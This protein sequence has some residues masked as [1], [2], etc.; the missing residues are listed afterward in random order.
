MQQSTGMQHTES[1]FPRVLNP[2]TTPKFSF[3]TSNTQWRF[4]K[5]WH[6]LITNLETT[7]AMSLF[8][9]KY[10]SIQNLRDMILS[11]Y[12]SLGTMVEHVPATRNLSPNQLFPHGY[13]FKAISGCMQL[14]YSMK[15]TVSGFGFIICLYHGILRMFTHFWVTVPFHLKENYFRPIFSLEIFYFYTNIVVHKNHRITKQKDIDI[16]QSH[17]PET[18]P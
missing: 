6:Y 12:C 13:F 10:I 18:A 16:T 14:E 1:P 8:Y 17:D 11:N 5:S 3:L 7:M 2:K 9:Q 4:L 15:I